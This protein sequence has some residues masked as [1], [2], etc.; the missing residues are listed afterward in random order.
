MKFETG[1]TIEE[2]ESDLEQLRVTVERIT[3]LVNA[4][5]GFDETNVKPCEA[6]Q[7]AR[8][9]VKH[10]RIAAGHLQQWRHYEKGHA[11]KILESD[12]ISD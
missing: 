10:Y 12:L 6:C 1:Q 8:L 4:C 11:Y 3:P 7:N 5:C 9:M 2:T